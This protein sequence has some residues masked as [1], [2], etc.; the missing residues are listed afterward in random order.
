MK[1]S[2]WVA[3]ATAFAGCAVAY[4]IHV[5]VKHDVV[6][7]TAAGSAKSKAAATERSRSSF[8]PVAGST[9]ERRPHTDGR[10]DGGSRI[11]SQTV[12]LP[13][14]R[15]IAGSP[16]FAGGKIQ[17][18]SQWREHAAMVET[19]A[20]HELERLTNLLDLDSTQQDKVFSSL[21]LQS[22]YWLPGMKAGSGLR[23]GS[24]GN[25]AESMVSSGGNSQSRTVGNGD[26]STSGG[27]AAL[28]AGGQT[29]ANLISTAGSP[30][31]AVVDLTAYLNADQ[32][33]TLVEA[34]MDRQAWWAEVL[35]QLL[36]PTIS[37]GTTAVTSDAGNTTS[38][39]APETKEFDGGDVLLEE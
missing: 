9:S 26:P 22:R 3:L 4:G 35:P 32:Q 11:A 5:F 12:I 29:G 16:V 6:E 27:N 13:Q 8:K 34:E 14:A 19:E 10:Q 31:P 39:P 7:S 21:A 25:S 37:D 20:N 33:Q 28:V 23:T 38:D 36:P 17:T 1:P 2:R 15:K 24:P 18:E 30:Q